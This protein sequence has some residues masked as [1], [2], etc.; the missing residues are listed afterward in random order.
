[1]KIH[2]VSLKTGL[3]EKAIRLYIQNELIHPHVEEGVQRNS[4]TFSETDVKELEEIAVFRKAGFSLF[5]IS[6]IK[7]MPEKLPELLNTKLTSLEVEIEEKKTIKEAISRLEV[8]ELGNVSQVAN[9]LRPA[10]KSDE[11]IKE[12]HTKRPL[13]ISIIL[14]SLFVFLLYAYTKGGWF[15]VSIIASFLC[16]LVGL[17]SC[18]MTIRYATATSRANKLPKKGKGMIV[19]V[20]EEHGFDI[21]FT[22]GRGTAGTKE[23]GI[24]GVWQILFMLW[25]E[26][27]PDCWFPVILYLTENGTKKSA[28]FLYGSFKDSLQVGDEIDISWD[29]NNSAIVY[30]LNKKWVSKKTRFYTLI[31]CVAFSLCILCLLFLF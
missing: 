2:E 28:T 30:P 17:I 1:M 13:Y 7:E 10:I 26:I 3:T 9:S 29:D 20:V 11:E 25:N 8:N 12:T 27:R 23:P 24:G 4:Y 6:L 14:L 19:S 31:S 15:A 22:A 16:F 5:E 21:G 18:I